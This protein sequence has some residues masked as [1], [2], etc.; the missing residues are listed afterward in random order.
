MTRASA[1]VAIDD[2]FFCHTLSLTTLPKNIGKCLL[3]IPYQ[4]RLSYPHNGGA[5]I[6]GRPEHQTGQDIVCRR[7]V[8][9]IKRGHFLAL[10]SNEAVRLTCHG[11][12]FGASQLAT[13]RHRF[14]YC[15]TPCLQK[16]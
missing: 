16:P 3:I 4:N 15:N 7:R 13:G 8:L 11:E 6:A 12:R 5:E 10:G 1:Y 9:Q 14:V 2:D